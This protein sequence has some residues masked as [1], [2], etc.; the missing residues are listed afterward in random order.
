MWTW[1]ENRFHL[2]PVTGAKHAIPVDKW[3]TFIRQGGDPA[4][5]GCRL[6]ITPDVQAQRHLPAAGSAW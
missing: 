3:A 2:A 4:A 5:V 6:E 1:D